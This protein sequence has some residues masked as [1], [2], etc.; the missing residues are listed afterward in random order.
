MIVSPQKITIYQTDIAE[1]TD[2][3]SKHSAATVMKDT[4]PIPY[5]FTLPDKAVIDSFQSDP[6]LTQITALDSDV[7]A[8]NVYIQI[9]FLR[10]ASKINFNLF[11]EFHR[12]A[13]RTRIE[14]RSEDDFSWFGTLN[15]SNEITII[16]TVKGQ[17]LCGNITSDNQTYHIEPI[18]P[19]L[20]RISLSD[21]SKLPNEHL[22]IDTPT[23][24][25][26][27]LPEDL[28][29]KRGDDGT[30]IHVMVVYTQQAA[31]ESGSINALIQL[32][33]DETN[34]SYETSKIQTR[35]NLVH[36]HQVDYMERDILTDLERL[37][38]QHDGDMDEI[39]GLRDQYCADIVVLIESVN[40]YC[41][42]S[43]L[44][45][46]SEHAF[47]VV[48]NECATGYYS[49]G[50]EIGHLYGARHNP[51]ADSEVFPY[52]YGHG[53]LHASGWRT[54][55]SYNNSQ[56]CP[57]GMC[58]RIL[59]W[60]NPSMRYQDIYMGSFSIHN[61]ARLLN[62]TAITL[63]NFRYFGKGFTINNTGEESLTVSSIMPEKKWSKIIYPPECPFE[64]APS[65]SR[66]FKIM[67]DWK[68]IQS[69]EDSYIWINTQE[70]EMS[71]QVTAI[72]SASAPVLSVTPTKI[73]CNTSTLIT[74]IQIDNDNLA[75]NTMKWRAVSNT[76]WITVI[77]GNRG[78][79]Q[80]LVSV[81]IDRNLMGMRTGLLNV[82][83]FDA[84]NICQTVKIQ[85]SGNPLSVTL[86]QKV[87]E[88]DTLLARA[89]KIS[90]P[91]PLD[92]SLRVKLITSDP[93]E[94]TVPE[95]VVIPEKMSSTFF[96]I[97]ILDDTESDGPQKVFIKAEA[98]G[99]LSGEAEINILDNDGQGIIY[100]G[101]DQSYK[102]IQD[103]VWDAAPGSSILVKNG[104]YTENLILDKTLHIYSE[105]GPEH[106]LIQ[107]EKPNNHGVE[108]HHSHTIIE[109][110][111]IG[112]A[113][114]YG[115]AAIYLS[116]SANNCLVKDNICG[117]N[118]QA[119]NY[120]GIFVDG[121]NNHTLS[122]NTCQYNKRYGI[123][124]DQTKDNTL[125][126]NTCQF[127]GKTG[128]Y[129][130]KS[131][132]NILCMNTLQY[133]QDYGLYLKQTSNDNQIYLNTFVKN[134][135]AHV[136]STSVVNIWQN[137]VPSNYRFA[138]KH[139]RG[140]LGNYYDDHDLLDQNDDGI[141]DDFYTLPN[142]EPQDEYPLV[143]QHDHYELPTRF[144]DN[145]QQLHHQNM[146]H[147][148]EQRLCSSGEALLFK[149]NLETDL[150]WDMTER[151]AWTGNIRLM[152]PLQ[153]NH[154]L[155]LQIGITDETGMFTGMGKA[156][157][158]QGDSE[159]KNLLFCIFPGPFSTPPGHWF[160][161]QVTN[162]SP[163]N[164]TIMTG[165]GQTYISPYQHSHTNAREWSVGP[166]AVFR[167][168]QS[169]LNFSE[170]GY[171]ITVLPGEYSEN[172]HIA[173][174]ISLIADKGYTQT[175]ISSKTS[176]KNAVHITA[177]HVYLKGFTIYGANRNNAAGICID[178]GV[179][180]CRI[181]NNR[182]GYDTNHTNDY[183]ILIQSSMENTIMNN[184]CIG[185]EKHGIWVDTSFMN[186]FSQNW[187][188]RNQAYGLL[189][190]HS[191]YNRLEN[192]IFENN[193]LRGIY[194]KKSSRN[195]MKYNIIDA[196]KKDGIY[197]DSDSLNNLI[198]LNNFVLNQ[199][200]NIDAYGVNR[201]QS[202]KPYVYKYQENI[203]TG[204]L[205]NYYSD[206]RMQDINQD[207][208]DD[209]PYEGSG[210]DQTDTHALVKPFSAYVLIHNDQSMPVALTQN[211]T[212]P[213]PKPMTSV[214]D[215]LVS[216][217]PEPL[218]EKKSEPLLPT[219]LEI[220][221]KEQV[222][223]VH[224]SEKK[225]TEIQDTEIQPILI[226]TDVPAYGNRLKNLKG[227]LLNAVPENHHIAVYI[228]VEGNGWRSK[229]YIEQPVISIG[230]EG[231]WECDITTA[232]FDQNAI[233]IVAFV[234]YTNDIPP[235]LMNAPVLP[236]A[237][238]EKAVAVVR[239]SRQ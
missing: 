154:V 63:A 51:E 130:L 126:Q 68:S 49:F 153:E 46:D 194:L 114:Y 234:F 109:G 35:L 58:K 233:E 116:K 112:G 108:I 57:G 236:D 90:V 115:K 204:Y 138:R 202:F 216:Q 188:Y 36:T 83:A 74:T 187:C 93:S 26:T 164:Y 28:S 85:Q 100:V 15:G 70:K 103:A 157:D 2:A 102:N 161:F 14:F 137:A 158:I 150:T 156:L 191:L 165:G 37:A 123:Y 31:L 235:A 22:P 226:F 160:A 213:E 94:I 5:L 163:Q 78:T 199:R 67:V 88:S 209:L 215:M 41:G 173:Q 175:V 159:R 222:P 111:S 190:T 229:P 131:Q 178:S 65:Q 43:Y 72:P 225:D 223:I 34:L 127:N 227:L 141:T 75:A 95:Y 166:N 89:G 3:S 196:N 73:Q 69:I 132:K 86:P 20:H 32:A 79:G 8:R 29:Y 210:T 120:D 146:S 106:T 54:I 12:I 148:Q 184:H 239:V 82:T 167:K 59:H 205:G 224:N 38:S 129:V 33:I 45:A 174:P 228:N 231:M 117:I 176:D 7:M 97:T 118:D 48:S 92:K 42:V 16:L 143:A 81:R 201:W 18:S 23:V 77:D 147:I 203:F 169:A 128:V 149:S 217:H 6:S 19:P 99:W 98:A 10:Y 105:N 180:H 177:D 232:P 182:C 17:A 144:A 55:M 142:D 21:Y 198:V 133:H 121:S 238:F 1:Q 170:K 151:D 135:K 145:L 53:Y 162:S 136:Y 211:Q 91:Q 62:E 104:I 40:N 47:C 27:D 200:R 64:I 71:V 39:H 50:H 96:D 152:Q 24:S 124:L 221:L 60:S 186:H 61:N 206:N 140:F 230:P 52:P 218:P 183:G 80:G 195:Q 197:I 113:N 134:T 220:P 76:P 139:C 214:I 181:E 171:T 25:Q 9:P 237:L 110:F 13:S 212:I 119:N 189:M 30:I 125:F 11:P 87:K 208:I 193:D 107:A 44:N 4:F 101:A 122:G 185:N 84:Q 168:I 192:N 172:I 207:G 219:D 179:A 56:I 66:S 155:N